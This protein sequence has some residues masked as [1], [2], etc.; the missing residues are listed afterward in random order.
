[1]YSYSL[2]TSS[3]TPVGDGDV[4]GT[5]GWR[6]QAP[7][8]RGAA[9][10]EDGASAARRTVEREHSRHPPSLDAGRDVADCVDTPVHAVQPT[11]AATFEDGV[12]AQ[13]GV[14]QLLNRHD[15][16]LARGDRRNANV[17]WGTFLGHYPSKAPGAADSPPATM[18]A[19][20]LKV[21]RARN[22]ERRAERYP[23]LSLV[24][25]PG[26]FSCNASIRNEEKWH[27]EMSA[28]R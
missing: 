15:S 3:P 23:S 2:S 6:Q 12:V 1:M 22:P 14:V 19:L 24:P 28:S 4:N 11:H 20:R 17:R 8:R 26:V 27:A 21:H 9:V 16:V 10:A 7:E 13:S 25:R 18:A 5:I